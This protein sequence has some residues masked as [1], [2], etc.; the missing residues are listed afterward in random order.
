MKAYPGELLGYKE[1]L[2]AGLKT[3]QVAI[4]VVQRH[5]AQRHSKA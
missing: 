4:N 5:P 1:S 3:R 2:F